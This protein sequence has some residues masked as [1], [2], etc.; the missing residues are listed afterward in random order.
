M[1]SIVCRESHRRYQTEYTQLDAHRCIGCIDCMKVC[2]EQV[3]GKIQLLW[4]KHA[5]IRNTDRCIG[6]LKCMKVCRHQA[7]LKRKEYE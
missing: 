6:C 2:P 5:V 7:I 4:H 3:I 1:T